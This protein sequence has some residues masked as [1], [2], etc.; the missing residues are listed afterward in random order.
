MTN[1]SDQ[2]KRS[3]KFNK[4]VDLI[5]LGV[6]VKR[7]FPN[8]GVPQNGWFIMENPIKIH[9]LGGPSLF[10]ETPKQSYFQ[11]GSIKCKQVLRGPG[12]QPW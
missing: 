9:D 4:K 10:L 3:G 12:V 2:K 11:N 1:G 7:V 5:Y 8:I 6:E